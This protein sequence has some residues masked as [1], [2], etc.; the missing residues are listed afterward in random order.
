MSEML[1]IRF[2]WA[3]IEVSSGEVLGVFARPSAARWYQDKG[4]R[5][6]GCGQTVVCIAS[7]QGALH[8]DSGEDFRRG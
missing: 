7:I 6:P 3:V 5:P 4:L 1:P 2:Y 8:F